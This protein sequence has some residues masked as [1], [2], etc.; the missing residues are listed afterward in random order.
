VVTIHAEATDRN[1]S[2]YFIEKVA[3][4]FPELNIMMGHL[5]PDE[6]TVVNRTKNMWAD[7]A[8]TSYKTIKMAFD[9]IVGDRVCFGSDYPYV[10]GAEFEIW[11]VRKALPS[12]NNQ[13]K[14]FDENLENYLHR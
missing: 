2:P 3:K 4:K 11:K 5:S 9:M 7:T 13:R 6:L 14:V 1:S 12:E 8:L 10:N